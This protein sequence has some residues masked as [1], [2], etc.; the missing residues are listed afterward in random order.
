LYIALLHD[1]VYDKNGRVVTSCVTNLDLHDI[2]RVART[3]ELAG[4]FVVHPVPSQEALIRRIV[5]H[6]QEGFG[7]AYNDT[8][9]EA[10]GIMTHCHSLLEAVEHIEKVWDGKTPRLVVTSAGRHAWTV[11]FDELRSQVEA[12]S[13]PCLLLFGTGWGVTEKIVAAAD[14]VLE[15]IRGSGRYNHLSVRSAV[16][17]VIDRLVGERSDQHALKEKTP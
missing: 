4:F 3:F 15:P 2:A 5:R 12:A 1:P 16:S 14:E 13:E 7:A 10:F 9:K 6:W 17:I 11:S 8:R